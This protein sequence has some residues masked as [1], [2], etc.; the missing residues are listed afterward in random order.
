MLL[1]SLSLFSFGKVYP[2][3]ILF[4]S[5]FFGAIY[6][7]SKPN[8]GGVDF[9]IS[10]A[11][12]IIIGIAALFFYAATVRGIA[13]SFDEKY[14]DGD[15]YSIGEII[16]EARY[17]IVDLFL[18]VLSFLL[19][20]NI[21][22]PFIGSVAGGVFQVSVGD[23]E[24]NV[25]T[26]GI[27][28]F[29]VVWLF[30]GTAQIAYADATFA[31]TIGMTFRFFFDHCLK[32]IGFIF[33][34]LFM[35]LVL[36]AALIFSYRIDPIATMPFKVLLFSYVLSLVNAYAMSFFVDEK[37]GLDDADDEDYEDEDDDE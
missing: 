3:A 30:F 19:A 13:V 8:A 24:F 15:E 11:A 35:H 21:V 34:V 2:L 32:T 7:L 20:Y 4:S 18:L 37:G 5:A 25:L 14:F 10:V 17:Y 9:Y 26:L 6:F 33:F 16:G 31:E 1:R 12:S 23:F 29:F 22:V 28:Y 27:N 36:Q